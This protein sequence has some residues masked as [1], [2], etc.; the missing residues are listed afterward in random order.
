MPWRRASGTWRASASPSL[1]PPASPTSW[2]PP[3]WWS[4]RRLSRSSKGGPSDGCP[5]GDRS[6]GRLREELRPDGRGQVHVPRARPGTQA[7]D[8]ACRRRDLRRE[9]ARR[10]N[11]DGEVQAEAAWAAL[12]PLSLLEEGRGPAG[13]GRA[14]RAVRGRGGG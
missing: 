7:S 10:P 12:R 11:L 1:P 5:P 13:A 8:R 2:A 14:D 3:P 6:A 4:P 9:G